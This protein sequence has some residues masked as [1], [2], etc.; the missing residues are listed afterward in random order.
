[1]LL[2]QRLEHRGD[3]GILAALFEPF[4]TRQLQPLKQDFAE[5]LGRVDVERA[6]RE[7][8]H[9]ELDRVSLLAVPVLVMI[10]R[11]RLPAGAADEEL[12]L[13]AETLAAA[14]MDPERG[15]G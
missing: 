12:L 7:V 11:E 6:A 1:V 10:G 8:E 5:L 2:G 14:A 3:R 4:A 13:E 15:R 9:V